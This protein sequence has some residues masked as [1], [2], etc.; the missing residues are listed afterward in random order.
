[1]KIL[2]RFQIKKLISES[3]SKKENKSEQLKKSKKSGF[4]LIELI[5]VVAILA[6]MVSFSI[7]SMVSVARRKATRAGKVIESELTLLASNTYSREGD[8]RLE[9]AFNEDEGHYVMTQQFNTG[10]GWVDFSAIN[11]PSSVDISFG[12]DAYNDNYEYDGPIY[13][14]LSREKGHYLTGT[15]FFCDNIFVHSAAKVVTIHM[16]SESGGH[17]VID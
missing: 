10:G 14:S 13:I 4:T 16:S 8:W 17:R 11:L 1:M 12:G 15:G 7:G 2:E 9:F 3:V 6:L 5:V